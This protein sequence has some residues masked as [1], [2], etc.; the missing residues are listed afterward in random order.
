MFLKWSQKNHWFPPP[1]FFSHLQICQIFS[2]DTWPILN[3]FILKT[4]R[5]LCYLKH[6]ILTLPTLTWICLISFVPLPGYSACYPDSDLNLRS[7]V[8]DCKLFYTGSLQIDSLFSRTLSS[9]QFY[10]Q[11]P[12]ALFWP[13]FTYLC[14]TYPFPFLLLLVIMLCPTS[15]TLLSDSA[16][17]PN[18]TL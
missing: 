2:P 11:R 17:V 18:K 14:V 9:L 12:L 16:I 7:P 13:I 8:N 6:S 3:H 4:W 1:D 10:T 5:N 15:L